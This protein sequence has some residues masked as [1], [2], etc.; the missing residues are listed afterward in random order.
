MGRIEM[1]NQG[2]LIALLEN[3]AAYEKGRVEGSYLDRKFF[4]V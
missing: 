2:N 3:S 4:K 1:S